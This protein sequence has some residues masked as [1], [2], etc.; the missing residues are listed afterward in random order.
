MNPPSALHGAMSRE[1]K[2]FTY[3][4][5]GLD[6]SEI[7][8]ERMA[9][10]LMRNAMNQ[11]V[12]EVPIQQIQSPPMPSTPIAVPNFN[13]LPVQVFPTINLPANPKSLLRTRSNPDQP[14]NLP[15][16]KVPP[17]QSQFGN[18]TISNRT[19][20][21]VPFYSQTNNSNFSRPA[22]MYEYSTVPSNNDMSRRLSYGTDQYTRPLL[23]EIS[24]EAEYCHVPT[25][26][27]NS[28]VGTPL[29][30]CPETKEDV[31]LTSNENVETI[32]TDFIVQPISD[33]SQIPIQM[34]SK[35]AEDDA[36]AIDE[37]REVKVV[38]KQV[39]KEQKVE[40]GEQNGEAN[41]EADLTVK[42]PTKKSAAKTETKVEVNKTI[43]PDGTVE[44]VKVTTTKTTIDGR[45]E[46]KTK[47]EKRVIPKQETEEEVVEE[48]E[49]EQEEENEVEVQEV[50]ENATEEPK[51]V[52]KIVTKETPVVENGQKETIVKK[53]E[54]SS[55]TT[56]KVVV[57]Q[58]EE[59][60]EEEEEEVQEEEPVVV[61]KPPTPEIE[62][63]E[64]EEEVT[65][66]SKEEKSEPKVEVKEVE[67]TVVV[68]IGKKE[69]KEVPAKQDEEEEEE[70][71][72]EYEEAEEKE[73][74]AEKKEVIEEK[75]T[76]TETKEEKQRQED[77]ES[78]YTEEEYESEK[79]EAVK[80]TPASPVQETTPVAKENE[81][82]ETKEEQT[83][84]KEQELE[85]PK[86][87]E[88]QPEQPKEKEPQS[89][90]PASKP[91]QRIPQ[92]EQKIPLREPSI[93]LEKVEEVEI[94][95]IGANSEVIS[96][97]HTENTEIIKSTNQQQTG[98]LSTQTEYNRIE[99][100]VTVNR[101]TK[102]LDHSYE[103][104]TQQGVPTVKTY[105][106]PN[107]ERIGTS[108]QPAR[109]YQ[110]VYPP[111]PTTERRHSL[112]LDR[113]S[114]ERQIPSSD[115]YQNTYQYSNQTLDQQ[116]QWS[117]EPQSEVLNV[118]NV[119]PSKITNQQW[120]QQNQKENVI[121]NNVT[122]TIS[123]PASQPWNQQSQ[124]QFQPQPQLQ[125]QPQPQYQPSYTETSQDRTTNTYQQTNYPAYVPKPSNW[126]SSNVDSLPSI[127]TQSNQYSFLSKDSSESYQTSTQQYS[128][129][130]VPPPWEQDSSYVVD[131]SSQNYYQPPP[132]SSAYAA[133]AKPGWNPS[134]QSKFS[135][136]APTSYIPP[137]PN[138]SFVKTV[139]PGVEPPRV[140]GRKTYY[141]EYERRYITVPESTYIPSETKFQPQ[142]DP[143]PQYYYDN[144]E[145]TEA[146]EH[147]W[148]KELREF[149]EK[150]SQIE[151]TT[152]STVRPPWEE[153]SKY[154]KTPS[155]ITPTPTWSQTLRPRSWRER[156]FESEYVG[157]Q[158]YP[159]TNTLGRGRPL[160]SYGKNI[161]PI[162]ERAR[163]VSVDRYN[164][165]NY[166]SPI[167]A[168][169]PPVQTH[170][171]TPT[172]PAKS[173]H[174]PNVPAYHTYTRAS[175]EPRELPQQYP[176]A[177]LWGE[178][179]GTPIQSRSF[180]YLQWITGTE[181]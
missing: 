159:K 28:F 149:T 120:Y 72:E 88:P 43:L 50:E 97:S 4:P 142:P 10:R 82:V 110:P 100:I 12:P 51:E 46:I 27:N 90:E 76:V 41:A 1:R 14:R 147:E 15:M 103:Q 98:P 108:P 42:L 131:T 30:P 140:P 118:S 17:S 66:E 26:T 169:H 101:T 166:Q 106:A 171:L 7:K 44:E 96:K 31:T 114:V 8:S 181:D 94:K 148:R 34:V 68:K 176:Q 85:Q 23:P 113:L 36:A 130:Y 179:R 167:P 99:N 71:E 69:Q 146:V 139:N 79:E 48:E 132:L 172:P 174:N 56:K 60:E 83:E 93:P 116:R 55:T 2:P 63:E 109:P 154:G 53:E 70:V 38:K 62:E 61:K 3:T 54:T 135:K 25:K 115:I 49:E 9:K 126:A 59:S 35:P 145:P 20:Q 102:T 73:V 65:E 124:P 125:P 58:K 80:E 91:E 77:E 165:N 161:E 19:E 16:Q 6:L 22:T 163:G 143:S 157:S 177:R 74:K 164:P 107:R 32:S 156:S 29:V 104:L 155:T 67:E 128:S 121:Y 92:P 13:C 152:E 138:Q 129:S 173:Y 119:K 78:E 153:D 123:A 134:P 175:A 162:P 127:N 158:E 87:P 75:T 144:N 89:E 105:F 112:L 40:N 160:S 150:S 178:A 141:S 136:T 11:G 64:E 24:Y 81:K 117:Q 86:Q 111:E 5:G 45:T 95:P 57:V 151:Q 52:V 180:K 33:T 133:D 122:P 137:A 47:T 37:Q 84:V 170:T 21:S 18:N 168:E 39:K